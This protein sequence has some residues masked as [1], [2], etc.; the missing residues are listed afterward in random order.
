MLLSEK[1]ATPERSG[2]LTPAAA[3]GT[4]Q[5][6]RFRHAGVRIQVSS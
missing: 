1:G 6:D 3:L 2:F 5:L 4:G